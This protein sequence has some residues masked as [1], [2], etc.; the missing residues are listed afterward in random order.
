[1]AEFDTNNY[2]VEL[3]FNILYVDKH[4]PEIEQSFLQVVESM[5]VEE[6]DDYTLTWCLN[7]LNFLA[8]NELPSKARF[9]KIEHC[10]IKLL[11]AFMDANTYLKGLY[12]NDIEPTAQN[13]FLEENGCIIYDRYLPTRQA[14]FV[15]PPKGEVSDLQVYSTR[16]DGT[17][18][19]ATV[20]IDSKGFV[21]EIVKPV[22]LLDATT[23]PTDYSDIYTN[24][25]TDVLKYEAE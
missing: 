25:L 4:D 9:I 7:A 14:R 1:M 19:S 11:A 16:E 5:N 8:I 22:R 6:T 21:Q 3:C 10:K 23:S 12:L 24:L 17:E 18:F 13:V 2:L 15:L 20:L